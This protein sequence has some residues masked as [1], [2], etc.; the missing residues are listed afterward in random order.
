MLS[1]RALIVG[2]TTALGAA[3]AA[4]ASVGARAPSCVPPIL[5][6]SAVK[7]GSVTVSPVS[8]SRDG[9]PRT[10]IS[11]LGVPAGAISHV[12]VTGSRT[13]LHAGG[14]LGYSQRGG[15]GFVPSHPFSEGQR[16]QRRG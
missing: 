8:G 6:T 14:L 2:L 15:A 10:Q 3:P 7:A 9:T 11:F 12:S 16:E 1:M 5:N 13:G 4:A